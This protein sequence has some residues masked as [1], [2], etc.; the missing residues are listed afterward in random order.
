[1]ADT[2]A[3]GDGESLGEITSTSTTFASKVAVTPT[4][5]SGTTYLIIWSCQ[6]ANNNTGGGCTVRLRDH[7]GTATLQETATVPKDT[8]DYILQGS[9]ATFTAPASAAREFRLDF[10]QEGSG[11]AAIKNARILILAL[12]AGDFAASSTGSSSTSS[13]T[14]QD[15]VSLSVNGAAAGDYLFVAG[16]MCGPTD[17]LHTEI[18]GLKTDGTTAVNT[19]GGFNYFTTLGAP[20]AAISVETLS[21][22]NVSAKIQYR[23]LDGGS[24]DILGAHLVAIDTSSLGDSYAYTLDEIDDGGTSSVIGDS[25]TLSGDGVDTVGGDVLVFAAINYNGDGTTVSSFVDFV[26]GSTSII[27]SFSEDRG[28]DNDDTAGIVAFRSA[29]ANDPETWKWRR[30]SESGS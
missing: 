16:A 10:N 19:A 29:S 5:V 21:G 22:A 12:D 24:V 28:A 26:E 23:S 3:G 25:E 2:I 11:T 9:A 8:T 18:R 4:L 1:M 14:P 27:E 13:G 30:R 15:K 7:T 20:W 6:T 17:E